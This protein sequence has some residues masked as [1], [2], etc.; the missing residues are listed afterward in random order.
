MV[1]AAVPAAAAAAAAAVAHNPLPRCCHNSPPLL[2]GI[3]LPLF[4]ARCSFCRPLLARLQHIMVGCCLLLSAVPL[5]VPHR[6]AIVDD[7][8]AGRLPPLILFLLWCRRPAPSLLFGPDAVIVVVI[9]TGGGAG[10]PAS[11]E[12]WRRTSWSSSASG[13]CRR[14]GG[15]A[16]WRP[17][18][19]R[20]PCC[21]SGDAGNMTPRRRGAVASSVLLSG[22]G[23]RQGYG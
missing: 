18:K 22:V 12:P 2:V 6:P 23:V 11:T 4:V 15:E 21:P 16:W 20:A 19:S 8:V 13:R 17:D 10:L 1:A 14:L 5:V 3:I 7:C 9:I